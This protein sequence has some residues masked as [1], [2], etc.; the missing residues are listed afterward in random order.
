MPVLKFNYYFDGFNKVVTEVVTQIKSICPNIL[1]LLWF[2]HIKNSEVEKNWAD[3]LEEYRD[4]Y[5]RQDNYNVFGLAVY[6][7]LASK[8]AIANLTG[9]IE[10]MSQSMEFAFIN[11]LQSPMSNAFMLDCLLPIYRYCLR[12]TRS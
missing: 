9:T 7:N 12:Q 11:T 5:D 1:H 4:G 10:Q 6:L 8:S 3:I 2:W